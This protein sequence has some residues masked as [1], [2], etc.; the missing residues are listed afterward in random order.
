MYLNLIIDA[1]AAQF[2][3]RQYVTT[4]HHHNIILIH[5]NSWF[6]EVGM[7]NKSSFHIPSI[8]F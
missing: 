8:Q 6:F 1:V 3:C 2:I 7:F 5:H 4:F